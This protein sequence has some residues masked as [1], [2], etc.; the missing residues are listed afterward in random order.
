M[1]RRL[2]LL[3]IVEGCAARLCALHDRREENLSGEEAR[4]A[5]RLD[6]LLGVLGEVAGLDH[7]GDVGQVALAEHLEVAELG[8]VEHGCRAGAVALLLLQDALGDEA[9]Q[10]VDVHGVAE[11]R[12]TLQVE[13]AHAH[14][15]EVTRVV[16][17]HHNA[18]MV[19]TT[20][21]TASSGVRSVLA[22]TAVTGRHV[23]PLLSVV[24]E[25]GRHPESIY[26]MR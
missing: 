14:L 26:Q 23:A 18:V 11:R 3:Y 12:G 15:T 25:S 2:L 21:V 5:G 4:S 20:G 7:D 16:L 24:V 6:L 17:V 19:L 13:V 10:L 1:Y 8:H 9:P 22:N